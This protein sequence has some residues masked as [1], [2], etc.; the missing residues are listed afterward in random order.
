MIELFGV[1]RACKILPRISPKEDT[2]LRGGR[3][4]PNTVNDSLPVS[5]PIVRISALGELI[6]I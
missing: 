5:T 4:T 3:Y 1:L 6:D 2:E